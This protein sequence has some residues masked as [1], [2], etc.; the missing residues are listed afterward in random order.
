MNRGQPQPIHICYYSNSCN[1]SKAFI[2]EIASTPFRNKFRFICVD[3]SPQR[4]QLPTWLKQVPTLVIQGEHEPRVDSNVMN[5]LYEEKMKHGVDNNTSSA[6]VSEIEP[7]PYLHQEM[8]GFADKYSFFNDDSAGPDTG[9]ND[10]I[11]HNFTYLN[12]QDAVGT[13]EATGFQS[14]SSSNNKVTDKEKMFNMQYEQMMK[15]RDKGIFQNQKMM[16]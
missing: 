9:N 1:W 8:G 3:P 5:W 10:L 2:T 7:E 16:R 13:R 4:P 11:K 14:S 15:N 6:G 12:G